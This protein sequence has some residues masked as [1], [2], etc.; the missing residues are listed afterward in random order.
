MIENPLF[1]PL[2]FEWLARSW[3]WGHFQP[4]SGF[5]I[6]SNIGVLEVVQVEINPG[7]DLC[8]VYVIRT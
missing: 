8:P 2:P 4:K 1:F 7:L 5:M 6:R 3:S